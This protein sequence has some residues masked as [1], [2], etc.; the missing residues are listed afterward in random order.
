LFEKG[1]RTFLTSP[2]MHPPFREFCK[3]EAYW[4]DDFALYEVLK[5][6][7][8]NKP[9]YEWPRS[10]RQR[11]QR[12]LGDI[13]RFH[14]ERINKVKWTQYLFDRQWKALKAYCNDLNVLMFGDLP[15]YV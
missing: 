14:Q 4:L 13:N 2:E 10:Y 11:Q 9:W 6:Q 12:A 15:F 8:E 5:D 7:H 1:F 3:R